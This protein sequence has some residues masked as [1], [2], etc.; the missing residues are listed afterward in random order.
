MDYGIIVA[1]T[2]MASGIGYVVFEL[3]QQLKTF[4]EGDK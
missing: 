3:G 2:L 4:I 1:L